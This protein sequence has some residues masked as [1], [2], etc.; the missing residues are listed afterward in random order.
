MMGGGMMGPGG[1][2]VGGTT[3]IGGGMMAGS[4]QEGFLQ[5]AMHT[6]GNALGVGG[7]GGSVAAGQQVMMTGGSTS[8]MQP[9]VQGGSVMS[10]GQVGGGSTLASHRSS[11]ASTPLHELQ[12]IFNR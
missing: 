2:M 6:V 10:T 8:A 9:V 5:H 7:Q 1:M 4:Q 12:R 11:R 3:A